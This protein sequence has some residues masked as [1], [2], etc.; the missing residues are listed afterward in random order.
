MRVLVLGGTVFVSR[1]VA[2]EFLARGHEATCLARRPDARVPEGAHG[3]AADREAGVSAYEGLTGE[4]DVVVDV[5]S[6][7]RFV[8]DALAVLGPRARHWVYV[9]SISTS[10]DHDTPH[11]DES[12]PTL[13]PLEESVPYDLE[14]YGEAKV[15][16]EAAARAVVGDRLLVA[17]PGLITGRG[18]TSDRV[19]YWVARFLREGGPVL[20]PAGHDLFV[21]MVDVRDLAE[22]LVT[23]AEGARVGTFNVVGDSRPLSPTLVEMAD[24]LDSCAER[25]VVED[26]WL[27][28]HEVGSWMGQ[29]SLPLWV[30]LGNGFDGF[31]RYSNSAATREGLTLRPLADTM[32]DVA[33]DELRRGVVRERRCGLSEQRERDLLARWRDSRRP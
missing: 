18:D 21:Q 17:R 4:W 32:A 8:R 22:W 33:E 14:H 3:V 9:S 2:T 16:S 31:L 27:L 28:D 10:A 25:V 6:D 29:D 1:E 11:L 24:A 12:A 26:Q 15:A 13:P 30:P 5:A 23:M 19:G 7:P 20:V